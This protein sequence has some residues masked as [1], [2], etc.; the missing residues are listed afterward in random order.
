MVHWAGWVERTRS[1]L[2][3]AEGHWSSHY[4]N[5]NDLAIKADLSYEEERIACE[6]EK[7]R[8]SR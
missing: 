5:S 7:L 4:G 1:L 3:G 8:F 6:I 2:R